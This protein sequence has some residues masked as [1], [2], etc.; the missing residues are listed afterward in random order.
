M[1]VLVYGIVRGNGRAWQAFHVNWLF[2]TTI[3]S[4]A[5]MFVA[6]QRITTARW[7]RKPAPP[8]RGSS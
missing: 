5:V 4:A 2:F 3:S 7:S 6:V 8:S 1:S